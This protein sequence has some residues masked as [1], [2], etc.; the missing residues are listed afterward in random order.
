MPH[1]LSCCNNCPLSKASWLRRM[2]FLTPVRSKMQ[3][4]WSWDVLKS[5]TR[6]TKCIGRSAQGQLSKGS[7]WDE[8]A[9]SRPRILQA[10]TSA[11][12]Q[13]L[14]NTSCISKPPPCWLVAPE[15]FH[16]PSPSSLAHTVPMRRALSTLPYTPLSG[17]FIHGEVFTGPAL[18]VKLPQGTVPPFTNRT[19]D[20]G[21][22]WRGSPATSTSKLM[23]VT[24]HLKGDIRSQ[25]TYSLIALS[26]LAA[27]HSLGGK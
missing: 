7:D 1:K 26:S 21:E 23:L 27:N 22:F 11:K 17:C 4:T 2:Q 16:L 24:F 18:R 8:P 13:G 20:K 5:S 9:F 14:K 12:L 3:V 19:S 15:V 10:D 25:A 6:E